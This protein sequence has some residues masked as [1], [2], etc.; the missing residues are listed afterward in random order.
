LSS[1]EGAFEFIGNDK[2]VQKAKAPKSTIESQ[3]QTQVFGFFDADASG[4]GIS[5]VSA[6]SF[7]SNCVSIGANLSYE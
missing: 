6:L 4:K 7:L 5:S 3:S 1:G 2:N